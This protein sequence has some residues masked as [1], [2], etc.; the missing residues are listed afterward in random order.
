MT[1]AE[2]LDIEE[3]KHARTLEEFHARDL[4][5]NLSVSCLGVY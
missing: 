3:G 5:W 2:G 4:A 1:A